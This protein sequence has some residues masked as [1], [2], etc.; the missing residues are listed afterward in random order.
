MTVA[1]GSAR[2]PCPSAQDAEASR[3]TDAEEYLA[4]MQTPSRVVRL[5]WR[6]VRRSESKGLT[7]H[8]WLEARLLDG[9]RMRLE[10][11]SDRGYTEQLYDPHGLQTVG[12]FDPNSELYDGRVAQTQDFARP[13]SASN[14][15]DVA[16]AIAA[17]RQ[18]SLSEFNCHHFVLE[19]WN[20]VVVGPMRATHY[21]DRAKTGLLWGLEGT[22]G[23]WLEGF[24]SKSLAAPQPHPQQLQR[25]ENV[26]AT[27][28]KIKASA[29]N[30]I[31]GRVEATPRT[32]AEYNRAK[33][34][35]DFCHALAQSSVFLL[36]P[37][38]QLVPTGLPPHGPR[39]ADADHFKTE[40]EAW[41][42]GYLP[43]TG[44]AAMRLAERATCLDVASVVARL[45]EPEKSVS[46]KHAPSGTF[47]QIAS[48]GSVAS[49][50]SASSIGILHS[51]PPELLPRDPFA[52]A[53]FV[54]LRGIR[55][56]RLAIFAVLRPPGAPEVCAWRLLLL[57]GD[58]LS[59]NEG[60]FEYALS[61][62][63][64][65]ESAP[66]TSAADLAQEEQGSL[67]AA[68]RSGDWGLL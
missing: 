68:L 9:R 26:D 37:D 61:D 14:L 10:V 50:A 42:E 29:C 18:Y 7:S 67:Q 52:D 41:A 1:A 58:A 11:Y 17:S 21:P 40:C 22:L 51:A 5:E 55:E 8:S 65:G 64:Q 33:R 46:G 54:V 24:S 13:L 63:P 35:E 60:S 66:A 56:L 3:F 28:Q 25:R 27:K 31:S 62:L 32:A 49:A 44:F 36:E 39:L 19:V 38:G 2:P 45:F 48:L 59:G 4:F 16:K 43:G 47:S 12:F 53:C 20:A 6:K 57:S 23:S 34:L 15:C 30:L